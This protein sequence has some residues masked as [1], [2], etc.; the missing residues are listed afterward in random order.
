MC[1]SRRP[2]HGPQLHIS[3]VMTRVVITGLGA[4][5]PLGV[6]ISHAWKSVLSGRCGIVSTDLLEDPL[7][8]DIPSK[9]VGK[10][11]SGSVKNGGWNTEEH[12]ADARRYPLF[13]QYAMAAAKE[14]LGDS[15]LALLAL[16]L[17]RTGVCVGLGIGSF[18]DTS[19]NAE[20]LNHGGYRKVK[21]LFIP[22]ILT[23]MAAG[24]ISIHYGFKG[25]LHSVSTACATGVHAIGD[26]YNFIANDY[27]DV[28]V[29]GGSE[30]LLTPLALAG[31]S[32]ARS[33]ATAYNAAPEKASRPFDKARS[34]FVLAEGAG[35]LVLERLEH[36]LGRGLTEK[37][38]YGEVL[39]YGLSG[40]A[41]HITAPRE[42][43]DGAFRAMKL[44][45]AR[46][47]IAPEKVDYVNAHAT[48]TSLGDM[49]ETTAMN[50]LFERNQNLSISSTK[51]QMGH[52]L[53]AA[54]AVE[55]IV[56]LKALQEGKVPPTINLEE[57]DVPNPHGFDFAREWR[58]KEIHYAMCNSFGFGGVNSSVLFGRYEG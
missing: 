21:P 58:E 28:M 8:R 35:I 49:A 43:G 20:G 13:V 14:A 54:G 19:E 45:L 16:D 51:S 44:A 25:P 34:G 9:V 40:D 57:L 4:V 6:G 55:A 53:G 10:V 52:L 27:A 23:N 22:R 29:A 41:F 33:V 50:A 32:R 46:A 39:G 5:T 24:N 7:W 12:F 47:K 36:A 30:A 2:Q 37:D 48:S 15:R 56:T 1:A 11:P 3:S 42:D 26:A 18:Q 17:D 31:F 38:F